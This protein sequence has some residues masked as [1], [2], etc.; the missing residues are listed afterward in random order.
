M[1]QQQNLLTGRGAEVTIRIG[2]IVLLVGWCFVIVQ[3]FIGIIGWS[4][5]MAVALYPTFDRLRALLGGRTKSAAVLLTIAFLLVFIV[6]AVVLSETLVSGVRT[7]ARDLQD[8]TLAIPL[9]SAA[10]REWPVIGHRLA[11]AWTLAATNLDT[12]VLQFRDEF[13][14]MGR[15]LLGQAATTGVGLLQFVAAVLLSG[16]LL[17][18]AKSSSE[19]TR[20]IGQR[21]VGENGEHYVRLAVATT[22]S[23]ARGVLGVA[24]IQATMAGLGMLVVGIPGAGLWAIV[25]LMLCIVQIGVL[26]V[27]LPAMIY[28]FATAAT[29]TAV[30]FAVWCAFI[31]VIDNV[32]KPILLGRGVDVPMFVVIL[33]AIGGLLTMGV[34]GLFVGAIVLVLGY[35]TLVAWLGRTDAESL[36]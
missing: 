19:I 22:R 27:L 13:V 21:I 26:P 5:V 1:T 7:L 33:G 18:T 17:A 10:V 28:I 35:S 36:Q 11:D 24:L 6:P 30:L 3:P 23:V 16:V 15:W 8:G 31:M 20:R 9:P 25:A 2:L 14:G 32:L 4:V 12:A 34:I 29:T